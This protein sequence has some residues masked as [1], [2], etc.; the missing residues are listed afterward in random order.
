MAAI[1]V[2][3]SKRS[4]AT[5]KI[6]AL[7]SLRAIAA[8]AI[9]I[10][11]AG[12]ET[13]LN[14][15]AG[16]FAVMLFFSLSGFLMSSHYWAKVTSPEF[17]FGPYICRKFI[18]LYPFNIVTALMSLPLML[19]MPAGIIGLGL[20]ANLLMIQGWMLNP[21]VTLACNGPAWTQSITIFFYI[22]FP[23]LIVRACR[24]PRM[25]IAVA[26]VVYLVYLAVVPLLPESLNQPLIYFFPVMRMPDFVLGMI[27]WLV[28]TR[29][30]I[31]LPQSRSILELSVCVLVALCVMAD[32]WIPLY[33][34]EVAWWWIP[35]AL[36][37]FTFARGDRGGIIT[38]ALSFGPLVKLGNMS[39]TFYLL[40]YPVLYWFRKITGYLAIMMPKWLETGIVFAIIVAVSIPA[41]WIFLKW[42]PSKL[43]HR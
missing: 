17:R 11:H 2:P 37:L 38:R 40:H 19:W 16:V 43:N 42:L 22:I 34:R 5:A 25:F 20:G 3:G 28:C 39:F 10:H 9:F 15:A 13:K 24:N 8:T 1:F 33:Y 21:A 30:K 36:L 31:R 35:A 6:P 32:R 12:Y 7:Q 29:L 26:L 27:V 23:F 18:K 4:M 41:T 14:Q